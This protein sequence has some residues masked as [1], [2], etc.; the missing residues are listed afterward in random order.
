[1]LR[2]WFDT[3]T[4]DA[5]SQAMLLDMTRWLP[6]ESLVRDDAAVRRQRERCDASLRRRVDELASSASLN[7]FQKARLGTRFESRLLDAGYP[8]AF[9]RAFARE[10]VQMLALAA[11]RRRA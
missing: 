9:S 5:F 8:A 2:R 1:M 4:I 11:T 7:F 6:P 10:A 3:T